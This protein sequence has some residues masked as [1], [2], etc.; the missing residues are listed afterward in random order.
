LTTV[1]TVQL[2]RSRPSR[3]R[4]PPSRD[5]S[6]RRQ[7]AS[8]AC[9]GVLLFCAITVLPI[10]SILLLLFIPF[11]ALLGLTD[12]LVDDCWFLSVIITCFSF[13]GTCKCGDVLFFW[14]DGFTDWRWKDT[15]PVAVSALSSTQ[16][17]GYEEKK[18]I[19][20]I[21]ILFLIQ[22]RTRAPGR[23]WSGM[24][25]SLLWSCVLLPV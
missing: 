5:G 25:A 7:D 10:N 22:V 21:S 24:A 17:E 11:L 6:C 20:I 23:I 19:F 14:W 2:H 3:A 15:N 1:F 16:G 18:P 9:L 8:S 4:N 13:Q 12:S